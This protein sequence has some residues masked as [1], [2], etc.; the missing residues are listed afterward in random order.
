VFHHRLR[1]S[2]TDPVWQGSWQYT[3]RK[4]SASK[5]PLSHAIP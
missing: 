1:C 5:T 2:A 3:A 4:F